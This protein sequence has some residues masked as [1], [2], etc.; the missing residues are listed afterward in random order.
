MTRTMA[1][2]APAKLKLGANI[3]TEFKARAPEFIEPLKFALVD[4]A[5][6]AGDLVGHQL[7][8]DTKGE[9]TP[10]FYYGSKL[11]WGVPFLLLG[12]LLSDYVIKGND[13]V[14][15]ATIGTTANLMMQVRY[16]IQNPAPF[17]V[18]VFLIHEALLLPL[19]LLIVGPS[20]ATVKY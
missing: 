13:L 20:P 4:A 9:A 11:I 10:P 17:N 2:W 14:R 6:V 19:S 8:K 16:L 12:R 18:T 3:L 5:W 7:F 1:P 15:A